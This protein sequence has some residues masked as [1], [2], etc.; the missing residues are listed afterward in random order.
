[1]EKLRE[2]ERRLETKKAKLAETRDVLLPEA[3]EEYANVL[4]DTRHPSNKEAFS[5]KELRRARD[6]S[7]AE[8]DKC[9]SN[10]SAQSIQRGFPIISNARTS[11]RFAETD[12]DF[13]PRVLLK[14][15]GFFVGYTTS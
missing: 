15:L 1:M 2:R 7:R 14:F 3:K 8:V 4:E 12:L 6:E 11:E 5:A 10:H 13:T 9:V